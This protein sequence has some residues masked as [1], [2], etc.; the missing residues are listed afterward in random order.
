LANFAKYATYYNEVMDLFHSGRMRPA[1]AIERFG[2]IVAHPILGG[3]PIDKMNLTFE[4]Q[5]VILSLHGPARVTRPMICIN[6]G[7]RTSAS[8]PL[9]SACIEF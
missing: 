8:R 2:D 5:V 6:R 4:A 7:R 9:P 3:L 1:R